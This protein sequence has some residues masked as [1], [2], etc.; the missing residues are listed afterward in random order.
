MQR[1]LASNPRIA[2]RLLILSSLYARTDATSLMR[3]RT[4]VDKMAWASQLS[5][6][7]APTA[8]VSTGALH[9]YFDAESAAFGYRYTAVSHTVV[10]IFSSR[11]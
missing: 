8:C 11:F 2:K 10:C 4:I 7:S 3:M 5:P 9:A 6:L 1:A